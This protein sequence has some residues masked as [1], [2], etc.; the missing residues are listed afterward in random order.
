MRGIARRPL[1]SHDGF[2]AGAPAVTVG[3]RAQLRVELWKA[4]CASERLC[5]R[6]LARVRNAP[7]S[8]KA[9]PACRRTLCGDPSGPRV[10]RRRGRARLARAPPRLDRKSTRL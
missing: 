5:L 6:S 8:R 7:K 1:T 3:S 4:G 10:R 2:L 9:E